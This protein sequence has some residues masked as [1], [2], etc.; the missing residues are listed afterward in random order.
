VAHP[1]RDGKVSTAQRPI[2]VPTPRAPLD[3]APRPTLAGGRASQVR[4]PAL[5]DYIELSEFPAHLAEVAV[6]TNMA[7]AWSEHDTL[8]LRGADGRW[9]AIGFSEPAATELLK[10]L[11]E[12]PGCDIDLLRKSIAERSQRIVTLWRTPSGEGSNP[13]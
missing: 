4:G 1:D 7:G 10:R 2:A 6:W 8:L 13:Q 12:L 5:A 3:Q 11:T 9:H